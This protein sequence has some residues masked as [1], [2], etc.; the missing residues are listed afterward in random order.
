[1]HIN[2]QSFSVFPN[3]TSGHVTLSFD[4]VDKGNIQI[5][6]FSVIGQ[7]L[8]TDELKNQ[9]DKS[10]YDIDLS[11]FST[12]LYIINVTVGNKTM[13]KKIVKD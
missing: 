9:N 2:D 6:V 12:G 11:R 5:K 8:K 3:P 7:L 4:I 10:T 1:M 13:S